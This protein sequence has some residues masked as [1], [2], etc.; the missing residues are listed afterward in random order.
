MTTTATS[1]ALVLAGPGVLRPERRALAGFL[2]GCSGLTRGALRAGPAPGRGPAGPPPAR[3]PGSLGERQRPAWETIP[4]PSSHAA[5]F[6]R[7]AVFH[8]WNAFAWQRTGPQASPTPRVN[9]AFCGKGPGSASRQ[10][11]GRG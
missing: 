6:A 8:V 5:I 1:A 9:G 7:R 11:K 10:A 3:S 4:A 2:A